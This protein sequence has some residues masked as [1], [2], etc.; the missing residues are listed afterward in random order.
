MQYFEYADEAGRAIT[1]KLGYDN[2]MWYDTDALFDALIAY[3][4]GKGLYI[5]NVS[6]EEFQA[7]VTR[8]AFKVE[9]D[10]TTGAWRRYSDLAAEVVEHRPDGSFDR[11]QI[12]VPATDDQVQATLAVERIIDALAAEYIIL[13]PRIEQ[14]EGRSVYAAASID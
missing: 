11:G 9:I 2:A 8:A 1:R 6:D 5:K 7:L 14:G 10:W 3:E 4:D 12:T 13:G